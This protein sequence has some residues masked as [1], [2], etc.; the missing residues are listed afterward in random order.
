[1][2]IVVNGLT[3]RSSSLS[4]LI[5][6]YINQKQQSLDALYQQKSAIEDMYNSVSSG[7]Y[8][9]NSQIYQLNNYYNNQIISK[10]STITNLNSQINLVQSKISTINS[11]KSSYKTTTTSLDDFLQSVKNSGNTAGTIDFSNTNPGAVDVILNGSSIKS[12]RVD[13]D[14]RQVATATKLTSNLLKGYN[15]TKNSKLV[16]LFAG[17]YKGT[18]LTGTRTDLTEDMTMEQ[19]GVKSGYFNIGDTTL[20]INSSDTLANVAQQL[21]NDGYDAGVSNGQFYIDSRAIKSMNIQNTDA[22]SDFAKI[23]GLTISEG[24][25]SINGKD[26]NITSSTTIQDLLNTV[27]NGDYGVAALFEGNQISFVANKT[28]NVLIE[29]QKGTSNISNALGFTLGGEMINNN[30]VLGSD[31][32]YQAIAGS[33]AISGIIGNISGGSFTITKTSGGVDTTATINFAQGANLTQTLNN[34]IAQI[35]ASSLGVTAEIVDDKFMIRNNQKGEGFKITVES[36]NSDFTSKIGM[37]ESSVSIGISKP[38]ADGQYFT[39]LTGITAIANANGVNVTA[40]SF[41]INNTTINLTAGTLANAIAQINAQTNT[42]GVIAEFNGQNVVLRNKM[43]GDK[44][45]YVEGGTSSF[46]TVAGLTTASTVAASSTIGQVG[47][48]STLTGS[49]TINANTIIQASTVKINGTTINIA[50]GKLSDVIN[51]I[52]ATYSDITKVQLSIASGKL[53]IT[54]TRNGNLPISVEAISGNFGQLTGIIGYQVKAGTEEKYGSSRTTYTTTKNVA[55]TTQILDSVVSINGR[56]ISLKG[57]ISDV[58]KT[59]NANTSTTGVEA[60]IDTNNKFSLRNVNTGSAGINFEVVSG[61]FGRVVGTGS[62]STIGG[63]VSHSEKKLA[64]VTGANRGLDEYTQVLAGSKIQFGSTIIDLGASVGAALLA[65]NNNKET[66]GVEALLNDQGQ[67]ILRA[68]ND[69]TQSISFTVSG[70]GDFGR[71]TGLGSYTVGGSSS[72][73]DIVNATYSK[74][75]GVN[76]VNLTTQITASSI[77]LGYVNDLGVNVSKNFNL[78][79]GSLEEAMKTINDANWYVKA[80]IVNNKLQFTSR[81][82]GPFQISLNVNAVDG[83]TGDFGRVAG[84]AT[85]KTSSGSTS[86]LGKDPAQYVGA[87]GGLNATDQLIGTNTIKIWMTRNNPITGTDTEGGSG[88]LASVAQTITF[89]DKDGNGVISLQDAIDSINDVKSQTKVE[90]LIENGRFVLR[91][92]DANTSGEGDTI[93]YQ[94][95]GNGDFG[96]V[97]GYGA[98]TTI[99]QSNTGTVNGQSF[100]TLAGSR[101]VTATNEVLSSSF[102]LRV[103]KAG[104]TNSAAVD[105]TINLTVGDGSLQ[106]A[107]ASINNQLTN[108][109]IGV[110]ASIVDNK[111]Q[112]KSTLAGDYNISVDM[113]NS[114]LGRV[115]GIGTHTTADGENTYVNKTAAKVTGGV[116]GLTLNSQIT[117]N[118]NITLQGIKTRTTTGVDTEGGNNNNTSSVKT[119][120]LSGTIGDAINAI[121]AQTGSTQIRAYLDSQGR[122]ILEQTN[123]N[124]ANEFDT[125]SFSV[126]GSGDF[127]AVTGLSSYVASGE[128]SSGSSSGQS[129]SYIAGVTDNLK[130]TE[131]VTSGTATIT[132]IDNVSSWQTPV[133]KT[134]TV[135]ISGTV[136][137]VAEQINA[138]ARELGIGVTASIDKSTGRFTIKSNSYGPDQISISVDKSDFARITGIANYS[139]DYAT[140][141]GGNSSYDKHPVLSGGNNVTANTNVLSGTL[142]IGNRTIS[143]VNKTI[144]QI[145]NEVNNLGLAGVT[146]DLE[147]GVFRIK[148]LQSSTASPYQI[149]A[150]G[151]FARITGLATYS[152]GSATYVNGSYTISDGT[153]SHQTKSVMGLSSSTRFVNGSITINHSNGIGGTE[154]FTIDTMGKSIDQIVNEINTVGQS[155]PSV[156]SPDGYSLNHVYAEYTNGQIVIKTNQNSHTISATGDF[157][158]VTGF[159]VYNSNASSNVS[160]STTVQEGTKQY[161][162]QSKSGLSSTTKFASGIISVSFE[163]G[164]SGTQTVSIDTK[165]KTVEQVVNELQAQADGFYAETSI[166]G[167]ITSRPKFSFDTA[168]GKI[169]ISTYGNDHTITATGDFARLTGFDNYSNGAA[170]NNAGSNTIS[171]GKYVFT[172]GT[173]TGSTNVYNTSQQALANQA[174]LIDFYDGSKK[175]GFVKVDEGDSLQTIMNKINAMTLDITAPSDLPNVGFSNKVTASINPDGKLAISYSGAISN[176][177]VSGSSDVVNFYGLGKTGSNTSADFDFSINPSKDIVTY[178]KDGYLTGSL[179][180]TT[181]NKNALFGQAG[182]IDFYNGSNKIGSITLGENDTLDTVLAKI[183]GMSVNLQEPDSSFNVNWDNSITASIVDNKIQINYGAGMQDMRISGTSSFVYFYGLGSTDTRFEDR[184]TS[185]NV[186][187]DKDVYIY[188]N[189]SVTGSVDVKDMLNNGG[190]L[191]VGSTNIGAFSGQKNGVLN[192]VTTMP[193]GTTKNVA[194][195]E[196]KAGDSLDEIMRKINNLR[197]EDILA[198]DG[199]IEINKVNG[200]KASFTADGKIQITYGGQHG[201]VKI[202]DTSGF[203]Q[204]YGLTDSSKDWTGNA[205]NGQMESPYPDR[206]GE[207]TVTG[208]S[209][210]YKNSSVIGGLQ[211]GSFSVAINGKSVTVNYSNNESVAAI[212]DRLVALAN[213]TEGSGLFNFN[214]ELDYNVTPFTNDKLTYSINSQGQIVI[215]SAVESRT[216]DKLVITDISGNFARLAGI[217][218][219]PAGFNEGTGTVPPSSTPGIVVDG[220]D[221]I[222]T[223]YSGAGSHGSFTYNGAVI[224]GLTGNS[225]LTGIKDG[226]F[227]MNT[228]TGNKWI[229]VSKTDTV[230]SVLA[231]INNLNSSIKATFD[232][233]NSRIVI[234]GTDYSLSDVI[235]SGDTSGFIQRAGLSKNNQSY[236]ANFVNNK[237]S[238]GYSKI[239]GSVDNLHESHVLGNMQGGVNGRTETVTIGSGAGAVDITVSD[240]ESLSSVIN[241]IKATGKYNAGIKDGKFWIQS[242]TDSDDIVTLSDSNFSRIVGLNGGSELLGNGTLSTGSYGTM[243]YSGG[244]IEGLLGSSNLTIDSGLAGVGDGSFRITLG[245]KTSNS[246]NIANKSF[247]VSITKDMTVDDIMTA[248]RTAAVNAG[249]E[250][251]NISFDNSTHQ[252]KISVSGNQAEQITFMGLDTRGA[253]LVRRLGLSTNNNS[254]NNTA[255][256]T[257]E[258]AGQIRLTGSISGLHGEHVLGGLKSETFSISGP[259]GSVNINIT[260]GQTLSQLITSINAQAGGKYTANIDKNGKFYIESTNQ[261]STGIIISSTDFT[262]RVGLVASNTNEG[263]TNQTST[264]DHGDFVYKGAGGLAGSGVDGMRGYTVFSGLR[265]G[266]F[267]FTLGATPNHAQT[268]YNVNVT[269]SDSVDTIL[270]KM[271]Q[272]I[273]AKG[274]VDTSALDFRV[275]VDSVTGKGRIYIKTDG[276]D[277]SQITFSSDTSNFITMAGMSVSGATTPPN[278]SSSDRSY[279]KAVMTGSVIGLGQSF[280]FGNMTAGNMTITAGSVTQTIAIAATDTIKN[281]MDKI[282][283]GGKFTAGLD[284]NNSFYIKSVADNAS[285]IT[286][287]GTTDFYKLAGMNSGSWNATGTSSTGSYGYSKITGSVTGLTGTQKF[288][289]MTSGTFTISAAG[290]RDLTVNVTQ[291]ATSVQDVINFINTNASSDYRASLDSSGKLVINTNVSNGATISV[292]DGTSNYAQIVGLTSGT[293]G[294]NATGVTGKEDLYSTLSGAT[295]GLDSNAKFSA[296]DFTISVTNPAGTTTSKTFTLTGNESLAEIAA[297]ITSSTLGIKASL[298]TYNNN[299]VL[300]SKVAGTFSIALTDGT[301]NFAESTGFTRNNSQVRP[302]EIG[303]LSTLTSTKTAENATLLGYSSGSFFVSLT[304]KNGNVTSTKKIDINSS[305]SIAQI[306]QAITNS[307]IGITAKVSD[308]TGQLVLTR[309]SS[310]TEGGIVV[311]KGTSDFTN[312]IGFTQGGTLSSGAVISQGTNAKQAYLESGTLGTTNGLATLG[313]L[314][315][316]NGTF[317]INGHNISILETDTINSLVNKINASFSTSDPSGVT[318]KFLGGK[319]TLTS[320][321]PSANTRILVEGGSSNLTSIFGFTNGSTLNTSNQQA[322]LNSIYSINGNDYESKSNIISLNNDGTVIE[323][324]SADEI[325][326][327]TAKAIGSG[328]IDIGKN[329]LNDAYNKL[330]VFANRFNSSMTMSQSSIL[331]DDGVFK[332]LQDAIRIALTDNVGS[333]NQVMKS[334]ADIGIVLNTTN[335]GTSFDKL[336]IGVNKDKFINAFYTD[337]KKVMDLLVGDETAPLDYTKAGTMVRLKDVFEGS[338]DPVKGYFNGSVRVLATQKKALEKE[339]SIST[340]ELTEL[341]NQL[342]LNAGDATIA[343]NQTDLLEFLSNLE[344]QYNEISELIYK[345]NKQYTQ[346]LSVL[347]INKNN[348]SFGSSL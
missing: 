75:T 253:E 286:V 228:T 118:V 188:S 71:V 151:D 45:I 217:A 264:G 117:G 155:S 68:T 161:L 318:A 270:S 325:I 210:G 262:K 141:T 185:Y 1:M 82:A 122:F 339:L 16:N 186:E 20:Y 81:S 303:A 123:Q 293:M 78:K 342:S 249:V 247:D 5:G 140:V 230:N 201:A 335:M 242:L 156:N 56:N 338:L 288:N 22:G 345:L 243:S 79:D 240:D 343:K 231:K 100:S 136:E 97:A 124:T 142:K 168:T 121:N 177:S 49:E 227:F 330:V 99:G 234:T 232:E 322:G 113:N 340:G 178:N 306:A 37:T 313:S 40:G 344:K 162:S 304:D 220:S 95:T 57:N 172:N 131:Q 239:V 132:F 147:T 287:S 189:G 251:F 258:S 299:L 135:D 319:L 163:N 83:V 160:S 52:N 48:K 300:E 98:Y 101:D 72:N 298:D 207:S 126:A 62:Y 154:S 279:G 175:I 316:K 205:V 328:I 165:G 202:Q 337:S 26:V 282:A 274:G 183:N 277:A 199:A 292:K 252:V 41:K 2:G 21:K 295:T 347:V 291:G 150:T 25:F 346:S 51:N 11:L 109:G 19:I 193:D 74:L 146:A 65:I 284:E 226:G 77:T 181:V 321:A 137:N 143:T 235:F 60:Y 105:L 114:D 169:N 170:I 305:D 36:G 10:N 94:I 42:T 266:S 301:S 138:K 297:M 23:T 110:T 29:I 276:K 93:N 84:M 336:S 208:S 314:G 133:R 102:S 127:G 108:A 308:I 125:I 157:S 46:G 24:T 257:A 221:Y 70:V 50:G 8:T 225:V 213:Q 245:D 332:N 115:V 229:N 255:T 33:N 196:I 12:Q 223:T 326:R 18:K 219:A 260:G 302:A 104:A 119:I 64:T 38:G 44:N 66:T 329:S 129:N 281:I 90:A 280:V 195:I 9:T 35:N 7:Y 61:D 69:A 203:A 149:E 267:S 54:E 218:T 55:N 96:R 224:S 179:D 91:Q 34:V 58:L 173:L 17:D 315:V 139:M 289:N 130:G 206:L 236:D 148:M 216:T 238:Y 246:M 47:S 85:N 153:P 341:K 310:T 191:A 174:G 13:Y 88:A 244:V 73:G 259:N 171:G 166:D 164:I 275:E 120:T 254:T 31:G 324:E 311:T 194:T 248:I 145:V 312:K 320:N 348:P 111:L 182:T 296:G 67:F 159:S 265:N 184:S 331:G 272:A 112:F 222:V 209:L 285:D 309:D 92:I 128:G 233:K 278:F 261:S 197:T 268:S 269:S 283:A 263:S 43:T 211:S 3:T 87:T 180:V 212:M 152:V 167:Y 89:T 86:H 307:G 116:G 294:G 317:K 187:N 200:F 323:S 76:S 273:I 327:L 271:K 32:S 241:K 250:N 53:V 15:I 6:N 215:K 144:E 290:L 4:S 134:F 39:K 192:F 237:E 59:I 190:S 28:G 333:N 204:Y 158:R 27:N 107:I 106:S 14:I 256:H 30:L 214:G 103:K 198:P 80:E 176:F 334:L 63:N